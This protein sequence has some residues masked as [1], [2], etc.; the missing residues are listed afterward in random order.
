M[1]KLVYT[2][3]ALIAFSGLINAQDRFAKLNWEISL[4]MG[5]LDEFLVNENVTFGGIS[6]DYR[7]IV[8]ENITVGGNISW[9]FFNGSTREE[10]V[11]GT[12]TVSGLRQ[13]Y[14]NA[15]PIMVN[16]HYYKDIGES[17][18][19]FGTGVGGVWTLQRT[20]IGSYFTDNDNFQFGLMP[21]IGFNIP[22]SFTSNLNISAKYNLA[23]ASANGI[24]ASYMAFG[25][26]WSSWW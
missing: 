22:I 3:V 19:Y 1:K 12:T 8:K 24:E 26:G 7:K 5:D 15:I 17:Q 13:F 23:F 6:Y 14:F 18:I 9:N 10:L 11:S 16:A 21:E 4:P 25:I 2:I 20:D